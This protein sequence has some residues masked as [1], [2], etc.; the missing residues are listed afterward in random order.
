MN[1][2]PSELIIHIFSFTK[3]KLHFTNK[4]NYD[5]IE[6]KRKSFLENPI[7]VYYRLV[8][9]S[10]SPRTPM[11]VNLSNSIKQY[12]PRMKVG[13]IKQSKIHKIPLGFVRKDLTIYP[14]KLLELCLI[15]PRPVRPRNTIYMITR[16]PMYNIYSIWIKP[17][18]YSR[19]KLYERL[20]PCFKTYK[21]VIP[22]K[23]I[24]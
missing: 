22:N 4:Y 3:S 16:M 13:R 14:S 20:Y 24:N 21:Y 1:E 6:K 9:W 8:K 7:T 17:E 19:A 2:L 12:R 10:Y 23:Y 5:I 18:D 15:K 11:I